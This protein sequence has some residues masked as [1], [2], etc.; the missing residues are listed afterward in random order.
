MQQVWLIYYKH[1]ATFELDIKSGLGVSLT[2]VE[3]GPG[4]N[5]KR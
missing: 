5:E 2:V 1:N 4:I 3:R